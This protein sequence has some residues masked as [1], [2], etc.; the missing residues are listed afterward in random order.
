MSGRVGQDNGK[1]WDFGRLLSRLVNW[2]RFLGWGLVDEAAGLQDVV[3]VEEEI[4][5]RRPAVGVYSSATAVYILGGS[6]QSI[7][8]EVWFSAGG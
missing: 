1:A 7:N 6:R 4:E 8:V 2:Q 5:R 3:V